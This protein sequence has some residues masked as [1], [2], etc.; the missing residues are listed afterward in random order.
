[1]FFF[2]KKSK[3]PIPSHL[4][5]ILRLRGWRNNEHSVTGQLACQCGC[6]KFLLYVNE[7]K[8]VI[9]AKCLS[10][11]KEYEVFNAQKHGWDGFVCNSGPV[12]PSQV[13]SVSCAKCENNGFNLYITVLSQEKED[14]IEESGLM[15][16]RGNTLSK[17][18]W[19]NAF[20]WLRIDLVC[21]ECR[22][23]NKGWLDIET[24]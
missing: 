4:K 24:M 15:D 2:G 20:E 16:S 12:S 11:N 5:E 3:L 7:D 22:Q 14:F 17:E 23:K 8:T 19:V 9:N 1:M 10:C 13:S 18:D 6:K 21:A